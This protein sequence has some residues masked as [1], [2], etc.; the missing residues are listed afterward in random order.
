MN[1]L[2]FIIPF[3][4]VALL[5]PFTGCKDES[6]NPVLK[7]E[8][9]VHGFARIKSGTPSNFI[10]GNNNSAISSEL[11]WVSIDQKNTVTKIE[12]FVQWTE[13]YIDSEGNPRTANHGK[14]RVQVIEGSNVPANR[15]FTNITVTA[16]QLFN[17][18]KDA[19]FDYRDGKGRVSV[20]NNT[21]KPDRTESA[22][23]TPDDSFKLT[24]AF[25]TADG[26]YFDSWS[27]SVCSEF[28]GAN[29][30]INW[31]VVCVSDIAG[32]YDVTVT[33]A[34]STD[35]CCPGVAN[36]TS[37]V[38]LTSKGSG[39]YEISDYSFGLYFHWYKVYGVTQN[40]PKLKVE[41]T[42][43]CNTFKL[44]VPDY[45]DARIRVK[46]TGKIDL[47]AGTITLKWGNDWGDKAD[48]V[49]KKR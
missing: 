2:K 5:M 15:V 11:Q 17:L 45:F 26:R 18:F 30:D 49:M 1:K 4:A 44:D 32:T 46:A 43:V 47:A 25:T 38:T 21:F 19:T 34:T 29:C 7:P 16:Q 41:V 36:I 28:P 24:W 31:K 40:D 22:R 8:T 23:F 12:I 14:K 27:D 35:D 10:F 9:A 13:A 48:I 6:L 39:K 37:T 20:F 3:L 33:N 42:D